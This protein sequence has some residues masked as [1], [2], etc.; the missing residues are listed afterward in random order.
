MSRTVSVAPA[1]ARRARLS[2]AAAVAA[3]LV[4]GACGGEDEPEETG[5]EAS[6]AEEATDDGTTDTAPGTEETTEEPTDDAGGE[7][8]APGAEGEGG[9]LTVY[10][11][12][13]EELVSPLIEEFQEAS[14]ITVEVRYA[15]TTE[16]AAQLLEEG[17]A[18]PAQVFLSQDAGALGLIAENGLFTTLPEELTS[19]VNPE[20]TSTDGSWVGLTGRG[21][22]MVYD[23][24]TLSADEVPTDVTEF[25]TEEWS[26]RVGI[27]PSNASFQAFITAMRVL[28]G[29]DAAL[30]WL[31]GMVANDAQIF[32]GNGDVLEAVNSGALEVGLINSYYWA[33]QEQ[34]PTTLRGQL[35]FGEPGTAAALVNV[36]GA[37][38]LTGAEG[39]AEAEE[40][41]AYLLSEEGQTY[42]VEETY[43]Y[44]LIEGLPGPEG[45]PGLDELGQPDID[46]SDLS[47]LDRTV[48]IITEAGLL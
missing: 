48:E 7:S 35:Q 31:D 29:D 4:L 39:S 11:G 38:I 27:V 32:E 5:E 3:A 43:E 47:T 44:P 26:G 13:D 34:D 37:G 30:E 28:D 2:V 21:R 16:L 25:T 41:I 24:E 19:V 18:T 36:T 8:A 10:S 40:F 33:R 20:Y 46:L 17:D 1:R 14:G 9:T 22:V 42:F 6:P 45:L 12:R 15:G 23:S